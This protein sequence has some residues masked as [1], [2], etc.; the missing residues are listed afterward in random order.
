MRQTWQTTQLS[1]GQ[2]HAHVIVYIIV[3]GHLTTIVIHKGIQIV[4]LLEAVGLY[5]SQTQSHFYSIRLPHAHMCVQKDD[6]HLIR[7]QT[8]SLFFV[9]R[10]VLP[11]ISKG[12]CPCGKNDSTRGY[13]AKKSTPSDGLCHHHRVLLRLRTGANSSIAPASVELGL[14]HGSRLT[15]SSSLFWG[16]VSSVMKELEIVTRY[17][18][19]V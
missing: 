18:L 11:L 8:S 7:L 17:L 9:S 16:S 14:H 10:Q 3:E 5:A 1:S 4:L 19:Y 2:E 15:A 12:V 13:Y 6:Q